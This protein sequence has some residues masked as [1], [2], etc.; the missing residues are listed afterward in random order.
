[1][2]DLT[3]AAVERSIQTLAKQLLSS[4]EL[5]CVRMR[6]TLRGKRGMLETAA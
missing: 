1:M 2:A 5:S 4:Q 6:E 3:A